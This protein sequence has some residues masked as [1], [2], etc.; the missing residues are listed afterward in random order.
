MV[1]ICTGDIGSHFDDGDVPSCVKGVTGSVVGASS[2]RLKLP[3]PKVNYFLDL[4]LVLRLGLCPA[5]PPE[6]SEPWRESTDQALAS[7]AGRRVMWRKYR[8]IPQS[9]ERTHM[10]TRDR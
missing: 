9:R 1:S 10:T 7:D 8:Q 4:Q 5:H 3:A 6:P 2:L